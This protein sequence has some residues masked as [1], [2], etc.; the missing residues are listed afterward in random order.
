MGTA[1]ELLVTSWQEQLKNQ[2]GVGRGCSFYKCLG[3]HPILWLCHSWAGRAGS[4]NSESYS[5]H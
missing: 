3:I 1:Q 5:N 2:L 4:G